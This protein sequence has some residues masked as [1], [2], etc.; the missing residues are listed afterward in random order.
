MQILRKPDGGSRGFGFVTY[1]DEMSVEKCLVMSHS[2]S[3]KTVELKRAVKKEDMSGGGGMGMGGMGMGGAGYGMGGGAGGPMR[4]NKQPDWM[5]KDCGNKNFGWREVCNRCQVQKPVGASM[6]VSEASLHACV[7]TF[8]ACIASSALLLTVQRC[9]WHFSSAQL[10][11][12][13]TAS[14]EPCCNTAA[15]TIVCAVHGVKAS[16][17][18]T[19]HT[20]V[21]S[22]SVLL[23]MPCICKP[24]C[25]ATSTMLMCRGQLDNSAYSST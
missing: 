12:G 5:C 21:C 14:Q 6:E 16:C 10:E 7:Y 18:I 8:A 15:N 20:S 23:G 9:I 3:G 11:E 4:G 22:P 17:I 24:A 25:F 2:L 13:V 1:K 19:C